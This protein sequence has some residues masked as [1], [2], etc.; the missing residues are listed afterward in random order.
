MNRIILPLVALTLWALPLRGA[1]PPDD[2]QFY[3]ETKLLTAPPREA[4][5]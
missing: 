5:A 2:V 1:E 4:A 3:L